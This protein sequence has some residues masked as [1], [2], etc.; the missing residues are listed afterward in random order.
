[1]LYDIAI[2]ISV[3][4]HYSVFG[5]F[6]ELGFVQSFAKKLSNGES[7]G[8]NSEKHKG[9][10]SSESGGEDSAVKDIPEHLLEGTVFWFDG[11]DAGG[12]SHGAGICWWHLWW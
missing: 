6:Y 3:I 11:G 2:S 10:E 8:S 5:W 7:Y 1:M 12:Q 4:N 9:N